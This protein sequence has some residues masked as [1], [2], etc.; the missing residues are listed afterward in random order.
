MLSLLLATALAAATPALDALPTPDAA[1][2][3]CSTPPGSGAP[4]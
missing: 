3:S 4:T 1:S 2:N